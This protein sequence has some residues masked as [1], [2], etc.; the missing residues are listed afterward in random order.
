M[1][2]TRFIN[3][4]THNKVKS[5]GYTPKQKKRVPEKAPSFF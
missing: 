1:L 2:Q 3:N 4:T 5:P